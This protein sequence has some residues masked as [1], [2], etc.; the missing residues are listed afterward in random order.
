MFIAFVSELA[1]LSVVELAE[2]RQGAAQP[3]FAVHGLGQVT[4]NKPRGLLRVPALDD[5]VGDRV[6]GW[7][8]DQAA[9]L[10]AVPSE[11]LALAPIVNS[12]SAAM[13]AF[14]SGLLRARIVS[15]VPIGRV[16]D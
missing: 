12:V 1:L 6:S 4:W 14:P 2:L 16:D 7:V 10:A 3:N 5:K 15:C 9:H 11:Q 8:D 13:A